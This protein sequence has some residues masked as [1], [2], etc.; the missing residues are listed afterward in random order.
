MPR[1]RQRNPRKKAPRAIPVGG[2]APPPDPGDLLETLTL[3]NWSGAS[4]TD[5]YVT[6]RRSFASGAVPNGNKVELR[7]SNVALSVQQADAIT[8]HADGSLRHA[9]FSA[10]AAVGAVADGASFSLTLHRVSGAFSNTSSISRTTLTAQDYK[11]RVRIAGTDYWCKL[12][13]CDSAGTYREIRVG[14]AVRAWHHWGVLRGNQNAN[15]TDQGTMQV[16]FFSYVWEDGRI[17]IWADLLNGRVATA[18]D[19]TVEELELRNGGTVL[20]AASGAFTAHAHACYAL[21]GADGLPLWSATP[22]HVHARVN[23]AYLD[24]KKLAWN[25]Q[26]GPVQIAAIGA[27]TVLNHAP[28]QVSGGW[29]PINSTGGSDWVGPLPLWDVQ[30]ILT[31]DKTRW[32]NAR[33]SALVQG[34]LSPDNY[35]DPATGYLPTLNNTN[36][37]G[38]GTKQPGIGWGVGTTIGYDTGAGGPNGWATLDMSHAPNYCYLQW[39]SSGG[40]WWLERMLTRIGGA[41]GSRNPGTGANYTRNPLIGGAQYYGSLCPAGIVLREGAWG[42]RDADNLAWTIPDAHLNAPYVRDLRDTT[43]A[44]IEKQ[45][46]VRDPSFDTL[47]AW[48]GLEYGNVGDI[49]YGHWMSSYM[50]LVALQSLNR[51]AVAANALV[52]DHLSRWVFGAIIAC[53]YHAMGALTIG[54]R[55]GSAPT[56]NSPIATSWDQVYYGETG[57]GQ[58]TNKLISDANGVSGVC[59]IAGQSTLP[60]SEPYGAS[61]TYASLAHACASIAARMGLANAATAVIPLAAREVALGIDGDTTAWNAGPGWRI[62]A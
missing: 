3:D 48:P 25:I 2:G 38:L 55:Q 23:T 17:S 49:A 46:D 33:V 58:Q 29:G 61:H 10:K 60:G 54:I 8:L 20:Y 9:T 40:E 34:W 50:G 28:N 36:Y 45:L 11:V 53:P 44:T 5:P 13:N 16:R 15:G 21:V 35:V 6:F 56:I 22:T 12:N 57:P 14:A 18:A 62:R 24:A 30:A 52:F 59:P 37:T 39:I 47:G 7:A 43:L 19:I 4:R 41:L 1:N 27:G 31:A 51:G 42:L 32:R 26:A